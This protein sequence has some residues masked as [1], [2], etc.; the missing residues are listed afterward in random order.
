MIEE[1]GARSYM[2][3]QR[4]F[5]ISKPQFIARD[6]LFESIT[7]LLYDDKERRRMKNID[8]FLHVC[9]KPCAQT[10]PGH[11]GTRTALMSYSC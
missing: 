7:S 11:P 5:R 4:Q 6:W 3:K 2:H 10:Q 9:S 1:K 8:G